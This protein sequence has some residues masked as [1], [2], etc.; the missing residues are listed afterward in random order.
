MLSFAFKNLACD[1][2]ENCDGSC[3]ALVTYPHSPLLGLTGLLFTML[4]QVANPQPSRATVEDIPRDAQWVEGQE[5]PSLE[6]SAINSQAGE[7]RLLRVR[8]GVFRSDVVECDLITT[9]LDH[10]QDFQALSYCCGPGK[11]DEVMLC[12]SRKRYIQATLNAALKTFR[13]SQELQDQLLWTDGICID[14]ANKVEVDEQILLMNR[15]YTEATGVFVHLGLAER[16]MTQGLDL[17]NRLRILQQHLEDPGTFGTISLD[18]VKNLPAQGRCWE[19][20][21][22]LYRSPW[23]SRTWI[24]QEI[25]LSKTATLGI[26][27][28]VIDWGVLEKSFQ[29]IREQGLTEKM[30]LGGYELALGILNFTRLQ[31]IRQIAR[32]PND[33]SLLAVLRATR[34]FAV[35]DP[36]DKILGVLGIIGNLPTE[37]KNLSQYSLNTAQIY[38]RTALYL[39]QTQFPFDVLAHAGLQRR[40][41]Q[42]DMPSWVP[43]WYAD[44]N[45]LNE[46]PLSL[47]RPIPFLAGGRPQNA[48][49]FPAED[50]TYPT[51]IFSP[52]FSHDKIVLTSD[53]S[54]H[55]SLS[56]GEGQCTSQVLLAW[57]DSARACLK[58]S[59]GLIYDDVEEAFARTLLVDDLYDGG[60][61]IRARTA[62]QDVKATF[63]ATVAQLE[64][65]EEHDSERMRGTS[66]DQVQTCGMQIMSATRGRRFAI[67]DTGYMCLVPS[68]AEVGDVVAV[69]F[70]FPTPFTIR[71][72]PDSEEPG[73]TPYTKRIRA[74]LVGDSYMHGAMYAESFVEAERTGRQPYEIVLF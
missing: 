42:Q 26:G 21:H 72:E 25:A 5:F 2:H 17:M 73:I 31:E 7:I 67:T 3:S 24:I 62:I 58:D 22:R 50:A 61:A 49:L 14:Q 74:Q 56:P 29:F 10:C 15:I 69:F 41:G 27:R 36:R 8:K 63:R 55:S 32:S 23:I 53:A 16:Q 45:K 40:V 57:I 47:F 1:I 64:R 9:C 44:T 33:R 54:V 13:E 43:D 70:G 60:N 59:D 28:Y 65:L 35:T 4:L 52:G 66:A 68:C 6:Y 18:E 51:M 12:N 38:H 39:L 34:N 20:Y 19:E 11:R 30:L 71:L 46:R 37:L 48:M